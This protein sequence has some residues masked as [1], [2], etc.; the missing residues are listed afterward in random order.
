VEEQPETLAAVVGQPAVPVSDCEGRRLR[1]PHGGVTRALA[2]IQA[3]WSEDFTLADLA[4]AAEVSSFHL[5][6]IFRQHVGVTPSAYRRALRVRAAQSLLKA[7]WKPAAA[8]AECGFCDQSHLNRHFKL[9]TGVTPR[10]YVL[11]GR[12]RPQ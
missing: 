6:R 12:G 9:I 3:H 8:A 4:Q 1:R 5:I 7:G 10:Q 2:Y 11:G